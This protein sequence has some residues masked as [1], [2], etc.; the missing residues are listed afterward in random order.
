MDTDLT[1]LYAVNGYKTKRPVPIN[2]F[3]TDF[4]QPEFSKIILSVNPK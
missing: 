4:K 2:S 1:V 3:L